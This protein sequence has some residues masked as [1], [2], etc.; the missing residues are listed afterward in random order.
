[1][2]VAV[3]EP[4]Y[5]DCW[6]NIGGYLLKHPQHK[7]LVVS[8]TKDDNWGNNVNNTKKLNKYIPGLKSVALGYNT[9]DVNQ[10]KVA[11]QARAVGVHSFN[12]L[13]AE[14]NGLRNA[15]TVYEQINNIINGYDIVLVPLG[16]YHP[17]H[18]IIGKWEFNLPTIK[19]AEYPYSFYSTEKENVILLTKGL[20]PLSF[21]ISDVI[22]KKVEVFK[23]VYPNEM[24]IL[25][26]PECPRHLSTIKTEMFY[27]VDSKRKTIWQKLL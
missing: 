5:D 10:A 7:Y 11:Q 6:L 14:I 9:L 13:F 26:L 16:I 2:R 18:Q 12:E 24:F 21:D 22:E 8:V 3:I 4:H 15:D 1:M 27:A 23:E 19:Y 20:I 25:S 17:M